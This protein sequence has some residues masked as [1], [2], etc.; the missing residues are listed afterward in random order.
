MPDRGC[1]ALAR[2]AHVSA[3]GQTLGL[4]M[5]MKAIHTHFWLARMPVCFADYE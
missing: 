4:I 5:M 3:R 1:L 2:V